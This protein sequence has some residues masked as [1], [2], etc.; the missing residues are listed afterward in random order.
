MKGSCF[1]AYRPEEPTKQGRG[2]PSWYAFQVF[3]AASNES[4]TDGA[5]TKQRVQSLPMPKVLPPIIAR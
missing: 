5:E 2:I 1:C 3:P 4:A